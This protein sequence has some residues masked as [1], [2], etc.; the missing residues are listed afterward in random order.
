MICYENILYDISSIFTHNKNIL[1]LEKNQPQ[2][3]LINS[4]FGGLIYLILLYYVTYTYI[5]AKTLI[6]N[7]VEMN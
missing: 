3:L 6:T 2:G 4:L 7:V 5:Y 1:Y